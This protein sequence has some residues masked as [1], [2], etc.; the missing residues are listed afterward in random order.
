M[1]DPLL[2]T[3]EAARLLGVSDAF[4]E[5]DRWAGAR[6]PFVKIGSRAV[7]YRQ[8]VLDDYIFQQSRQST[9]ATEGD[10]S[11]HAK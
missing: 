10:P 2:T 8:S 7:R 9:S 6:I 4:L 11:S 1:A 5:R 3:K